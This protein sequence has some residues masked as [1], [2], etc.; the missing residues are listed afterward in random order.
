ML[1]PKSIPPSCEYCSD[2]NRGY[3]RGDFLRLT[4][5]FRT[6]RE[7]FGLQTRNGT[8]LAV[9]V[10]GAATGWGNS[11]VSPLDSS[12]SMLHDRLVRARRRSPRHIALLHGQDE[13]H[14][15]TIW[16]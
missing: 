4:R 7:S 10:N 3:V 9:G 5:F 2:G 14:P 1:S 12:Y 13:L 11:T 16:I 6:P 8:I 15:K